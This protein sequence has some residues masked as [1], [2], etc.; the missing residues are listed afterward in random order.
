M[1]TRLTAEEL[2]TALRVSLAAVR[3]WTREGC[4]YLPAGRLR[5]YE[6]EPVQQW[7]VERDR[8]YKHS[9]A[10][11]RLRKLQAAA[12]APKKKPFPAR[13]KQRVRPAA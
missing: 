13:M 12:R 4:P 3:Q 9:R 8:A 6:P 5:F 11:R 10:E 2:A 7:L 1:I